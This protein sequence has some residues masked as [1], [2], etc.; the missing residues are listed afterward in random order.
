MAE[1]GL[2]TNPNAKPRPEPEGA[3]YADETPGKR[4]KPE[5]RVNNTFKPTDYDAEFDKLTQHLQ[6][7]VV[8]ID[9]K[10]LEGSGRGRQLVHYKNLREFSKSPSVRGRIRKG[11]QLGKLK[12]I[13]ERFTANLRE[14]TDFE[15]GLYADEAPGRG[16]TFTL[17]DT[18]LPAINS[19]YAKQQTF[20]DY[21]TAHVKS[22]EAATRNPLGK[23]IV[24]LVPQF[25]LGRGLTCD[26]PEPDHQDAWNDFW[27]RHDMPIR[28]KVWLRELMTYGEQFNRHFKKG[29]K[30]VQRQ[31]DPCT[32]WDVVTDPE[33][34][35]DVQ[36]YY[37]QYVATSPIIVPGAKMPNSTLII[38]H[39]PAD[40]VDHFWINK[41]SSEK[42]G[43]SEL[44]AI[45]GWL[46][47]FKEFMNDRVLVNKMQTMFAIDVSVKGG[48]QQVDAANE[49]FRTPPGPGA[50]A[51]HNDN[52]TLE[53]KNVKGTAAT[54]AET[55]AQMI[56]R[57]CAIGAGV[58]EQFLGLGGASTRASA[59]LQTEP[60]VKN[61]EDYRLII[62]RMLQKTYKRMRD[63]EGLK[64]TKKV[65]EVSFPA[66]ATEDRSGKLK[67]LALM[68]AQG[69]I[70]KERA[71]T[72]GA[73]EMDIAGYDYDTESEEIKKE[74]AEDP[75]VMQGFQSAP[76]V[77][78]DPMAMVAAGAEAKAAASGAMAPNAKNDDGRKVVSTAGSMGYSA[79][80]KS[81]RNYA[82]TSTTLA[83]QDFTR[84]GERASI[85]GRK[86]AGAPLRAAAAPGWTLK[87]REASLFTRRRTK[88]TRLMQEAETL[89]ESPRKER[90]LREIATLEALT[91]AVPAGSE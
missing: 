79:K 26:V 60:D 45:L 34:V 12:E 89:P 40:Q 61:F 71:A 53:F 54:D 80:G 10:I 66:L 85:K 75:I 20:H 24:N 86:S 35:E 76:K 77:M 36:Y 23:R 30:L 83:R 27:D 65:F 47:R 88:L 39:I 87:A 25:V 9:A 82:N 28:L 29:G 58:S 46:L 56:L 33:D 90:I 42:R 62:E 67:D 14:A 55:D 15:M 7:Q 22:W 19:P 6:T 91:H 51:V 81:G 16:T 13:N 78:P 48:Q 50:I 31:I 38:R 63:V 74:L 64:P 21:M 18:V 11:I 2:I 44:Y 5:I 49:Q 72:L 73:R 59:L 3:M 37:Q 32:I 52:V 68:E 41:S 69:W 70:T 1:T 84:G 43:R 57:V 8:E 17:Q 4:V